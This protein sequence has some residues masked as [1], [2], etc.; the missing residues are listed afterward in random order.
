MNFVDLNDG[1]IHEFDLAF[2]EFDKTLKA[3][4]NFGNENCIKGL[5]TNLGVEELRAVLHY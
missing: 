4:L 2:A 3:N 5:A 1:S